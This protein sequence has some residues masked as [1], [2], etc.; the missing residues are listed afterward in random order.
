MAWSKV[1]G[2]LAPKYRVCGY[3]RAG[4]GFS[5]PGPE[6]R[7]G[8][9]VIRDLD[10]GLRAARLKGPFIIV[11]HSSGGLYARLFSNRRPRD[12]IGMVLVDPSVEHQDAS[13]AAVFGEGA[14]NQSGLRERVLRCL[15]E[16]ERVSIPA[17]TAPDGC[18]PRLRPADSVGVTQARRAESMRPSYWRTQLSELDNLWTRTSAEIVA[19]R[20]SYGDLPLVVL[21][22]DGAYG[23][24]PTATRAAQA[25]LWRSLH[26]TVASRSH[27]GVE[28]LVQG[29]S[30]L[31]ARDRPETIASAVDEVASQATSVQNDRSTPRKRP[32]GMRK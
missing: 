3:D 29:T 7:D 19:G 6:P 23:D 10:Q 16:A 14:G 12:V 4:Y 9:A 1:Q 21:T 26:V 20:Q 13:F 18:L 2:L 17:I 5:D 32:G 11:G 25:R 8:T 15:E 27:R 24:A 30:H 31:M 28:R 22:A